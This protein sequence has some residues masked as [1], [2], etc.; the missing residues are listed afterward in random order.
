M[1]IKGIDVSEF[2]GLIDWN[3]VKNDGVKF[4]ILR[5]GFG[6][7][8]SQ[9]DRCFEQNYQN[10]KANGIAVGVYL[11]SYASNVV[12]AESE[13]QCVLNWLNNRKLDLPIYYDLEDNT[14]SKLGR[15]TLNAMCKAFCDKI[16]KSGYWAGIYTNQNWA[17]NKIDGVA[18]GQRYTY[19]IAQYNSKCTYNGKYDMWQYSSSGK[20]NGINGNVDMNYMYRNLISEIRG[21]AATAT[22]IQ[23]GAADQV[24]HVGSKVQL[25]GIY[26]INAVSSKLNG[27][28]CQELVG[29]P[30]YQTYHYIDATPCYEVDRFGNK[31]KDQICDTSHYLKIPGTFKVLAIDKKT[32]SCK[33]KIG[34]REVWVYCKP[35][36]EV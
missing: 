8:S 25:N 11:Y 36:T 20:V 1:E 31:T 2:Q 3:K 24:L 35:C 16:E 26:K 30:P 23:T 10:A 17:I 33:I 21:S 19:W 13:A 28:I 14:Q 15:S 34:S 27:V 5:I 12:E 6:S 22:T 9:K 29:T 4:A 32:D 7:R 18:L